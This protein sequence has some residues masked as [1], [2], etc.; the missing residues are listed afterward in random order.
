MSARDLAPAQEPARLHRQGENGGGVMLRPADQG[1]SRA[2]GEA[3]GR[4]QKGGTQCL[5][6]GSEALWYP[7]LSVICPEAAMLRSDVQG[8][9]GFLELLGRPEGDLLRGLDLDRLT[10]LWIAPR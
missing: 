8:S 7:L 2:S 3:Y 10:G 6:A 5:G 4:W 9:N 1:S